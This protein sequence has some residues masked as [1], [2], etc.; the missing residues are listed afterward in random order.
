MQSI[1]SD[2][3][4]GIDVSNWQG[5]IDFAKVKN[6]GIQVVY[7]KATEGTYYTDPFLKSNYYNAKSQNL[8]VGFYHFFIPESKESSI[9]QAYYFISK[10]SGL[11]PDCKL[12][13]DV[14]VTGG[15]SKTELSELANIFLIEVKKLTGMDVVIYTYSNFANYNLTNILDAYP[16]WIAEYGVNTPMYNPIWD[17]WIG[18]QY[19]DSGYV[20]GVSGGVDLDVFT[21]DILL[22]SSS[23]PNIQ[24]NI[25]NSEATGKEILYVVQP[26][27]TLSEIA[28]KY[29]TTVD[30]LA[31]SNNIKNPNL[32]YPGETLTIY[33]NSSTSSENFNSI[34]IVQPGDTL[35][36]IAN[37]F[38]TSVNSIVNVNSI[39][40][41]NLIYP[42]EVLKIPSST[43]SNTG[44][45]NL[46]LSTYIV[47][48][49]D[50]L[51]QIALTHNTTID[52]LVEINNIQNPNLIYPGQI[53]KL[54]SSGNTPS[55]DSFTGT[56]VV[57]PND[58]L[59]EIASLFGTTYEHLA[60]LNSISD[61]NLIYPG[62]VLKI[63]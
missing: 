61:P 2:N 57:N 54:Y 26:G 63:S 25:N 17:S 47:Q 50:T 46:L 23:I 28:S 38:G 5:V 16:L 40:N 18:F 56:Y 27:D 44:N 36:N 4:K 7:T 10:I 52:Y 9:N 43:S 12:A 8:Y 42:G 49:G 19:S 48:E 34:Y 30:F 45:S 60:E 13:L 3:L 59:S 15:F 21:S 37:V 35:S 6:S 33:I 39:S 1:S 20:P 53:L 62:Q 24:P 11:T 14:E 55:N 58:T 41:P 22:N 32:I 29:N 31:L 51:S